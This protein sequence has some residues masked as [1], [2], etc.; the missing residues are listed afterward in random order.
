MKCE[1]NPNN[2]PIE[3]TLSLI[4][5]KYKPVILWH[6]I[7]QPLHYAQLERLIP[8]ATPKMLAQQLRSL[9]HCGLI[10]R[11][12]IPETPP[13]TLYSLTD[14]GRSLIPILDAMCQWG[15]HYLDNQET[16]C[17]RSGQMPE[18]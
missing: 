7:D 5:G 15:S 3:V 9:E 4:G 6:L 17:S 13:R 8:K 1:T 11:K 2:C 12:V 10:H 18:Q 14:F 16:T